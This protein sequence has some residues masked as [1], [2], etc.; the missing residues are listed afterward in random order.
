VLNNPF[1]Q[2]E[3]GGLDFAFKYGSKLLELPFDIKLND[4]IAE[5]YPGT[6]KSYSSFESKVSVLMNKKMI[7]I[8][9]FI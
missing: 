7:L 8:F 5:R 6:E 2:I 3:V 1:K 9:I 4:F